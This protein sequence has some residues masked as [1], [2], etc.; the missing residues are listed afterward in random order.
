M[1]PYQQWAY[2]FNQWAMHQWNCAMEIQRK[3][4]ESTRRWRFYEDIFHQWS[5]LNDKVERFEELVIKKG[6]YPLSYKK[7]LSSEI[8]RYQNIPIFKVDLIHEINQ[9]DPIYLLDLND[10][11]VSWMLYPF[12]VWIYELESWIEWMKYYHKWVDK[13]V[14]HYETILYTHI[15]KWFLEKKNRLSI[16]LQTS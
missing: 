8:Q 15:P 12:W 5:A 2:Y 7:H 10:P 14:R 1:N 13:Q 6:L 9:I 16:L 3:Y 11:H 4:E